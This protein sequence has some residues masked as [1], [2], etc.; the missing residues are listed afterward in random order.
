MRLTRPTANPG[1]SICGFGSCGVG[2]LSCGKYDK[3]KFKVVVFSWILHDSTVFPGKV[4][5]MLRF[6]CATTLWPCRN[7]HV[8]MAKLVPRHML[9]HHLRD[10]SKLIKVLAL[11]EWALKRIFLNGSSSHRQNPTVSYAMQQ[12][13]SDDIHLSHIYGHFVFFHCCKLRVCVQSSAQLWF[14]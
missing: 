7:L 14:D 8:L 6:V 11:I 10:L 1:S 9:C 3:T 13:C 12:I 4:E 2:P 5:K